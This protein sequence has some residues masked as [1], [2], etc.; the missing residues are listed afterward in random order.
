MS[1]ALSSY[2]NRPRIEI[3]GKTFAT[4]KNAKEMYGQI[5][6]VEENFD[7]V[8]EDYVELE[9]TLLSLGMR[10]LA[11]RPADHVQFHSMRSVI[12]RR[13]L[14]LLST[15]RLY[16]EALLKHG[17]ALFRNAGTF[18]RLEDEVLDAPSQPM[19]FRIVEA[20]RNYA[21][22]E[23]LPISMMTIGSQWESFGSENDKDRAA[24]S[25][26]PKIDAVRISNGRTIAADVRKA[27]E[28]L[29]SEAEMIGEI[30]E[31][32]ERLGAIHSAFREMIKESEDLWARAMQDAMSQYLNAL[33]DQKA[34]LVVYAIRKDGADTTDSIQLFSEFF[35]YRMYLRRKNGVQTN[36]SRRY[37]K[38][39]GHDKKK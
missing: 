3:S 37:V 28:E 27:L 29:G 30:R 16:R 1:F 5:I 38:W 14:H 21:Q 19:A 17:K 12:S 22:H 35:E 13:M 9:E 4:L 31:Y 33:H 15:A 8:M 6:R 7:A 24:Y 32:V 20:L 10:Y 11:F 2:G 18:R 39:S 23:E 26:A 36:L 25:I 34:P